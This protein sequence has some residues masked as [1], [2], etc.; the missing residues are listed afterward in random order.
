MS[1][2]SGV[3]T[4]AA[5]GDRLVE[6]DHAGSLPS[7]LRPLAHLARVSAALELGDGALARRCI[8][9]ARVLAH[10]VRTPTGWAHLQFA[11][12]GLA[13]LDGD[14]ERARGHA[15]ALR[16]AMQRV[17]RYTVDSS[18]DSI[19]AVVE[20]ESGDIGA[21]LDLVAPLLTWPYAGPIRWL[22]AWILVEGGRLDEARAA[23]AGFDGPLPDDWLQLPLTTAGVHAAARVRDLHFLRRHLPHLETLS[24]RFAFL[25]EGGF[26]VG[27]VGLAVAAGHLALGDPSAARRHAELAAT[28][29]E[30]IG[31]VRWRPRVRHF[32]DELPP[33]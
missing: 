32:L 27:P 11:E 9:D 8:G 22:R 6:L 13:L 24:D 30:R 26:T 31:A 20:T 33:V 4:R 19:L 18:P 2:P 21:A 10:P 5:I 28:L 25:G 3:A 16:L 7:R 12:A 23:L 29:V 14:L 17:R 15:A 1:G